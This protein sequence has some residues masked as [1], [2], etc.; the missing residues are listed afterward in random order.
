MM[1]HVAHI[2]TALALISLISGCD[3]PLVPLV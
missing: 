3:I 2:I 1:R